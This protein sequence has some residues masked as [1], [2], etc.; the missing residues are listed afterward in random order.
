MHRFQTSVSLLLVFI[1]I[2]SSSANA[3]PAFLDANLVLPAVKGT[4]ANIRLF[5]LDSNQKWQEQAVQVEAINEENLIDLEEGKDP[6]DS[7]IVKTD[8]VVFRLET[9]G[10][11]I[12]KKAP[13]PC[14][15]EIIMELKNPS[16]KGKYAYL[17][18]CKLKQP[19]MAPPVNHKPDIRQFSAPNYT[20][21]YLPNNQ[22]MYKS[23]SVIH[24]KT[25]KNIEV[26]H[27]SNMLLHLDVKK[28]FTLN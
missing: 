7:N 20:F 1:L 22:L 16:E 13:M 28:F 11:K 2:T 25:K 17:A 15:T 27:N 24:P 26:A 19:K 3:C 5:T 21:E 23:L 18:S 14:D 9:F 10:N 8:R 6:N 12:K 4:R